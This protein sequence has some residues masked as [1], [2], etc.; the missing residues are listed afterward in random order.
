M[1]ILEGRRT[2]ENISKEMLDVTKYGRTVVVY[3]LVERTVAREVVVV[4]SEVKCSTTCGFTGKKQIEM[5]KSDVLGSKTTRRYLHM[6]LLQNVLEKFFEPLKR[7][8]GM[9]M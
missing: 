4:S 7:S 6:S 8:G 1:F 5:G 2:K 9:N 3:P